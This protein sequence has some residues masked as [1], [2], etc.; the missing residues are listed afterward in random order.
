MAT[1]KQ[2]QIIARYTHKNRENGTVSYLVRSSNG[3]STYCCTLI[4]G[5]ASGCSCPSRKPCYHMTQLEAKEQER[6]DVAT[7]FKAKSAPSWLINLVNTG[8]IVAPNHVVETASPKVEQIAKE[9]G[10]TVEQAQE[11]AAIALDYQQEIK[12]KHTDLC[13]PIGP[14]DTKEDIRRKSAEAPVVPQY[15]NMFKKPW[16]KIAEAREQRENKR[17]ILSEARA[18]RER[19]ELSETGNFSS[20]A[21]SL[22][23]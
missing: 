22:M 12:P 21:F 9:V 7:Q 23:R 18:I 4:N 15:T 13:L 16:N 6:Q 17:E 11:L 2:V 5:K 3:K 8:K 20:K 14:H 19:R 10:I 1:Q